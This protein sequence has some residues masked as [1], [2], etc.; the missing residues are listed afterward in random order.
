MRSGLQDSL[1]LELRLSSLPADDYPSGGIWV[2]SSEA[3]EALTEPGILAERM[4]AD[5]PPADAYFARTL[6]DLLTASVSTGNPVIF[7]YNGLIDG[8]WEVCDDRRCDTW[9]R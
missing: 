9:R 8:A 1:H 7:H 2:T 6:A 5:L 4:P 3:A